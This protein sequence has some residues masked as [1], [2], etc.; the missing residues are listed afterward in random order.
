MRS[1]DFWATRDEIDWAENGYS[2]SINNMASQLESNGIDPKGY[3][4]ALNT[5]STKADLNAVRVFE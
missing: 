3:G 2:E 4:V 1:S 5:G